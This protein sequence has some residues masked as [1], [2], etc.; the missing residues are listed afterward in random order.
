VKATMQPSLMI[1]A[2]DDDWQKEWFDYRMTD[3]SRSTHK[4]YDPRWAA[5]EAA[6]LALEVRSEQPNTLVITIEDEAAEVPLPGGPEWQSIVLSL[7]DFTDAT[8]DPLSSWNG[9]KVLRL[10]AEETLREKVEGEGKTRKVG[11]PWK[12]PDPEFRNLRWVE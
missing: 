6:T 9:I 10:C 4:V 5:P 3:W 12:G 8:G 11:G 2:F 1:E 7:A